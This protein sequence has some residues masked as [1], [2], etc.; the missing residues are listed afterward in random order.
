MPSHPDC[1]VCAVGGG[2]LLMGVL[3][4]LY[5]VGWTS[6]T[7]IV[8]AQSENCALL[9]AAI[10][11]GYQPVATK[12]IS[13][14]GV[15]LGHRAL[16]GEV[17]KTVEKF[18]SFNP[19]KSM[20]VKDEDVLNTA[21]LFG[22]REKVLIEPLCAVAVTAVVENKAYFKQFEN[23]VIIVCGGNHIYFEKERLAK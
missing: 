20:L 23:V 8:A 15:D 5:Q 3:M 13:S 22:L 19:I 11:N 1:I 10:Q 4:G 17:A 7:K 12:C 16:S 6:T 2:G 14:E 21:T 18:K 9:D